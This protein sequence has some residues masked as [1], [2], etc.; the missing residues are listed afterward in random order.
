VGIAQRARR[1]PWQLRYRHAARV[2]SELRRLTVLATHR[3]ATVVFRGPV[4]LGPGVSLDVAGEGTF[5]GGPGVGFRRRRHREIAGSG[6][7]RIGAGCAFTHDVLIQC[8]TSVDIGERCLLAQGV[9]V[10]DGNHRFRDGA[11][12]VSSQGYEYRPIRIGDD[13][14]IGAKATV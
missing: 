12:P 10:V 1:L 14:W 3:H 8:T 6:A 9:L 5:D 13:V 11:A 4:R 7:V 2:A